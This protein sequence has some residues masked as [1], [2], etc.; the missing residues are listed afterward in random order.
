MSMRDNRMSRISLLLG[1]TLMLL[2]ANGQ[3]SA[4]TSCTTTVVVYAGGPGVVNNTFKLQD[5]Y[6]TTSDAAWCFD[7][8]DGV[9]LDTNGYSITCTDA[10]CL[11][12]VSCFHANTRVRSSEG[13]DGTHIDISGPFTTGISEC[14]DIEDLA[15]DGAVTAVSS[16]RADLVANNLITNCSSVCLSVTMQS[17]TDRVHDNLIKPYGGDAV[18]MVGKSTSTGPRF[19][20]NV[21]MQFDVGFYNN[22]TTYIRIEDNLIVDGVGSNVAY[23]INTTNKSGPAGLCSVAADPQ[24]FCTSYYEVPPFGF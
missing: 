19:D 23:S 8:R 13:S 2:S 14:T 17:S 24:S 4:A 21:V 22:D 6:V 1:A 16:T 20:H 18:S 10:S 3:A 11:G 12:A 5:D 9:D 15:I 7:V